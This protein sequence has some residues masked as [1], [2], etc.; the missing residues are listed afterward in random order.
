[1]ALS[2]Q[3]ATWPEP[4]PALIHVA[5]EALIPADKDN[6]CKQIPHGDIFLDP[7]AKC[8][9]ALEAPAPRLWNL[10]R[11]SVIAKILSAIKLV[12][13]GSAGGSNNYLGGVL[14]V[15]PTGNV[16]YKHHEKSFGDTLPPQDEI[17][18]AVAKMRA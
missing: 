13:K 1:M 12:A 4:R 8:F 3:W 7:K 2:E 16:L 14:V 17:L 18:G 5:N 15:A 10:L 11:P 6:F 9:E